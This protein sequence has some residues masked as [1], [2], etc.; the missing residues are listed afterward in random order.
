MRTQPKSVPSI[1]AA[2]ALA[3][4]LVFCAACASRAPRPTLREEPS[5]GLQAFLQARQQAAVASDVIAVGDV[6]RVSAP[7]VIPADDDH[8]VDERGRVDVPFVGLVDASGRT[9]ANLE[10]E[11]ARRLAATGS[12]VEVRVEIAERPGDA[13]EIAGAVEHPGRLSGAEPRTLE[14]ALDSVGGVRSD[15]A[16]LVRIRTRRA[17]VSGLFASAEEPAVELRMADVGGPTASPL[18]LWPGD[19]VEVPPAAAAAAPSAPASSVPE[20]STSLPPLGVSTAQAPTLAPAAPPVPAAPATPAASQVPAIDSLVSAL[21]DVRAQIAS[22]RGELENVRRDQ[23][24]LHAAMERLSAPPRRDAPAPPR[25][26]ANARKPDGD[27]APVAR[28]PAAAPAKTQSAET[29]SQGEAPAPPATVTVSGSVERPGVY[30]V[31]EVR[32]VGGAISAAGRKQDGNLGAIE[33]RAGEHGALLG[34]GLGAPPPKVVVDLASADP[35]KRA[36]D[37]PLR[38]GEVIF[39]PRVRP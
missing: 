22:L 36:S 2:L 12:D 26:P 19:L 39:V 14:Q 32:T 33:I 9:R 18:Y 21:G 34:L 27:G 5:H 10:E 8:K 1:G 11:I 29:P 38:G 15:A 24:S 6:V 13:I 17:P 35:T 25:A 37:V 31:D 16:G 20:N 4:A 28:E 30:R 23:A 7:P 3:L